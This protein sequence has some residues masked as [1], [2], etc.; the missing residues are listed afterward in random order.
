MSKKRNVVSYLDAKLVRKTRELG[1]N[2][3]KTLENH[4]KQ[5]INQFENV[6]TQNNGEKYIIGSPGKFEPPS[7][8]PEPAMLG[9]YTTRVKAEKFERAMM[10]QNPVSARHTERIPPGPPQSF[11]GFALIDGWV[12]LTIPRD[13]NGDG[14]CNILDIKLVKL[15]YSGWIINPNA[16]IDGNS[17]INILDLKLVKLAYS[18]LIG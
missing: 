10:T 6:Y 8:G 14:E 3:S 7:A 16:D 4:L 5:L 18:D 11:F 17:V 12:L 15:A 9:H 13:A 2:L 1:F